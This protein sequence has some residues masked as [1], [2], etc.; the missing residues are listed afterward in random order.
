MKWRGRGPETQWGRPFRSI[1]WT[2]NVGSSTFIFLNLRCFPVGR[3]QTQGRFRV[4]LFFRR[5]IVFRATKERRCAERSPPLN[6]SPAPRMVFGRSIYNLPFLLQNVSFRE[7]FLSSAVICFF[8]DLFLPRSI[9]PAF[10]LRGTI[11]AGSAFPAAH[12][13][14]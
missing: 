4:K 12:L 3:I 11:A 9:Y 1:G 14:F 2:L 10:S 7:K 6:P 13:F 5:K 8:S